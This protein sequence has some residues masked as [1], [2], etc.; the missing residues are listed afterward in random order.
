MER[1]G[2]AAHSYRQ[3]LMVAE[4]RIKDLN[5]KLTE[6]DRERKSVESA[7]AKAKKQAENPNVYNYAE[8]R[9]NSPLPK[10]R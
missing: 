10:G 7:L 8:P 9:T 6:A 3:T 2:R 1:R 5:T 4:K